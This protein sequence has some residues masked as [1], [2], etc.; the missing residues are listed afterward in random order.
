MGK[1]VTPNEVKNI[2]QISGSSYDTVINTLI[3]IVEDYVVKYC[4]ISYDSA[5]LQPGLKLVA[6]NLINYQLQRQAGN[7]S[8]ETI[9]NYSVSYTNNYSPDLVQ[10]MKPYRKTL[11]VQDLSQGDYYS[12]MYEEFEDSD[13]R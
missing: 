10:S 9:G 4:N 12:E 8:S 2:L 11:F 5:S 1:I 6:S 3:P 7:I 13:T